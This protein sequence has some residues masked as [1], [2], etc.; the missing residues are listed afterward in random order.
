[1]GQH[2]HIRVIPNSNENKA[3]IKNQQIIIKIK[4]K[5]VKGKA[6]L[7][8]IKFLKKFTKRKVTLV[9]GDS[10]QNKVLEIEG[11]TEQDLKEIIQK[12]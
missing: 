3:I 9:R 10:T 1:M 5:P 12:S 11:L 7:E 6:N 4:S 2:I 8:L